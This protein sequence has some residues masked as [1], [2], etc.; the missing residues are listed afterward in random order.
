[1]KQ[2]VGSLEFGVDIGRS[3]QAI[4][5][6]FAEAG[7]QDV[8]EKATDELK[9]GDRHCVVPF[10]DER[11]G[12]GVHGQEPVIGESD[13]VG[14]SAEVLEDLLR[15]AEGSFCIDAP[16]LFVQ[17][18]DEFFGQGGLRTILSVWVLEFPGCVGFLKGS[19]E[20][21]S[22]KG[23][24]DLDGKEVSGPF[25]GYPLPAGGCE[26]T[27]G[28]DTMKMGVEPEISS[29]GM[30]DAGDGG[31]CTEA[32]RVTAQAKK[33]LGGGFKEDIKDTF[34]VGQSQGSDLS[35]QGEDDVEIVGGQDASFSFCDPSCLR[36]ALTFGAVSVPARV[37]RWPL[38]AA[39]MTDVQMSAERRGATSQDGTQRPVLLRSRYM[40]LDK[41]LTVFPEDV[42]DLQ[43]RSAARRGR[44]GSPMALHL[45]LSQ[46]VALGGADQIQRAFGFAD[47]CGADL[48]VPCGGPDRTMT[49]KDLDG[50]DILSGLEQMCGKGVPKHMRGDAFSKPRGVGGFLKCTA[51]R[52]GTDGAVGLVS[53]EEPWLRWAGLLPIL[54]QAHKQSVAEHDVS[55]PALFSVPDMD[56]PP[57]AVNVVNLKGTGL[58][59]AHSG[60]VGGHQHGPVFDGFHGIEKPYG[61]GPTEDI[62]QG[63][64]NFWIGNV[65]D[66][67]GT[68]KCVGVKEPDGRHIQLQ[69]LGTR[70]FLLFQMEQE[71]AD[72]FFSQFLRISHEVGDEIPGAAD[73]VSAGRRPVLPQCQVFCH[74]VSILSHGRSPFKRSDARSFEHLDI[75]NRPWEFF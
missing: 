18:M 1:M 15:A 33:C 6:Y 25:C 19:E 11:D 41:G 66:F 40:F 69:V 2:A 10:G 52:G 30:Q 55:I 63:P 20:L 24:D 53:G 3:Q 9:R 36:Q 61:L 39:L 17:G 21:A 5:P 28:Y 60:A 12:V 64:G 31:D 7:R 26:A 44:A 14:V 13:S 59:D 58:D 73:V 54:A 62:R 16:V 42:G 50:A 43:A 46:Q 67:L 8:Q 45:G 48:G 68:A 51:N 56:Q 49:E 70:P 75:R 27:G 37:V 29:P 35:R 72:F 34:G 71:L 74:P 38:V 57:R 4:V 65:E 23:S 47:M 32:F 22:K